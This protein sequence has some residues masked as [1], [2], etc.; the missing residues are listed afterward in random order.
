[1]SEESDEARREQLMAEL[2]QQIR[3]REAIKFARTELMGKIFSNVALGLV[4]FCAG[5][6]VIYHF[7]N[8]I[9]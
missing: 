6:G 1:M 7:S 4:G 8:L 2:D 9:K 5:I 3:K